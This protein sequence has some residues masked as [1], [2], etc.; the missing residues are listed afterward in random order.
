MRNS[1]LFKVI[2]SVTFIIV[3][4]SCNPENTIIEKDS[5]FEPKVAKKNISLPSDS[6]LLRQM[7]YQTQNM[8]DELID[9]ISITSPATTIEQCLSDLNSLN[10]ELLTYYYEENEL[11]IND[12]TDLEKD[13]INNVISTTSTTIANNFIT[14]LSSNSTETIIIDMLKVEISTLLANMSYSNNF[15]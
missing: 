14:I 11:T 13:Y 2:F 12:I 15:I 4:S 9:N 5:N 7:H 10:Q 8:L 3:F 6:N 1:I